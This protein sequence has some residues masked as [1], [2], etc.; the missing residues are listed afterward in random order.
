[1][2]ATMEQME[3]QTGG[4]DHRER[5]RQRR[6]WGLACIG[7]ASAWCASIGLFSIGVL[8]YP[9]GWLVLLVLLAWCWYRLRGV[10]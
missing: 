4:Q 10:S 3:R 2:G 6:L 5:E 8:P 1:M 9:W 7:L